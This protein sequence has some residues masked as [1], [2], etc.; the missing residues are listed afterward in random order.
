[1]NKYVKIRAD[2]DNATQKKIKKLLAKYKKSQDELIEV[3][4]AVVIQNMDDDGFVILTP[5]LMAEIKSDIKK[6]LDDITKSEKEFLD[7]VLEKAYATA[8]KETAK[9]IGITADYKI[10]RREFV[11]RAINA[12]I[13]GKTY[14]KR[15]WENTN[16][17]ANRIYS[18]VVD[19]IKTGKRPNHIAAEIKKDYGSTAYQAKRLVNTELAKVVNDAQMQIYKDSGVVDKVMWTATLEDNTCEDCAGLDGQY[20]DLDKAPNLPFHPNCRCCYVPVVDG[21]NPTT[22]ADNETK[23]NIEYVTYSEWNS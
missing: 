4:A 2:I 7:D 10:L 21:W 6:N 5:K 13:D 1:M 19:C 16:E 17:L 23:E 12:P 15:I 11:Q 18:D 20:F 8:A 14:S 3:I 9:T 22:R